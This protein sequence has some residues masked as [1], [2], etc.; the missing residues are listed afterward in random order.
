MLLSHPRL[1]SLCRQSLQWFGN[2]CLDLSLCAY[3]AAD[4]PAGFP[5]FI[6]VLTM[7]MIKASRRAAQR[8]LS[9][10]ARA[11]QEVHHSS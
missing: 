6:L 5:G 11:V 2:C 7:W 9:L 8:D 1:L 10:P 3:Y 4:K